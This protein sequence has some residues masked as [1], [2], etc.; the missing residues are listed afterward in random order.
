MQPSSMIL[1]LIRRDTPTGGNGERL[2][3][4]SPDSTTLLG[5]GLCN[6]IVVWSLE[7]EMLK[8]VR[9]AHSG[10]IKSLSWFEDGTKVLSTDDTGSVKVWSWSST[11]RTLNMIHSTM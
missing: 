11:Y 8:E 1:P 2:L 9:E 10:C 3:S 4:F 7:L 6:S 5:K